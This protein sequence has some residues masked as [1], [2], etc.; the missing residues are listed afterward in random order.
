MVKKLEGQ[1]FIHILLCRFCKYYLSRTCQILIA[2]CKL[3]HRYYALPW[4]LVSWSALPSFVLSWL[5]L[6]GFATNLWILQSSVLNL[7][8]CPS[9]FCSSSYSAKWPFIWIH[10]RSSITMVLL[11]SS[12]IYIFSKLPTYFIFRH[13]FMRLIGF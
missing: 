1:V 10:N 4:I 6:L 13:L 7:K 8:I 9:Y 2:S 5:S 11:R 12:R 3:I